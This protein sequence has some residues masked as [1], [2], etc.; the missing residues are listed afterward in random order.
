MRGPIRI[1]F[2]LINRLN[3]KIFLS[4]SFPLNQPFL[5]ISRPK[6]ISLSLLSLL[7]HFRFTDLGHLSR[8][9]PLA[10]TITPLF[11]S[12][13]SSRFTDLISGFAGV[14]SPP[15]K[16]FTPSSPPKFVRSFK[17]VSGHS[18]LS[19]LF[20]SSRSPSCSSPP[21]SFAV[22]VSTTVARHFCLHHRL[23]FVRRPHRF[24][25]FFSIVAFV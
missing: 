13:L 24:P 19:S 14:R 3:K 10:L 12:S 9:S 6:S 1:L 7:S 2:L 15:P 8:P 25:F 11:I 17:D 4:L 5:L 18:F 22:F 20:A 16:S 21:K 23:E